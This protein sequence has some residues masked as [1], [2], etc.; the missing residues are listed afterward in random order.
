MTPLNIL[1][2]PFT[3][4]TGW[5]ALKR[6]RPS[7]AT[8]A[9]GVVLPMSL[10]PP[11]LLFYA[12]TH[13]GDTFAA[14][15]AERQWRFITTILFLAE[16]LTFFVMGWLIQAVVNG[17]DELSIDYHSAYLLAALAPLP[18]WVASLGLLVPSLVVNAVLVLAALALACSLVYHG[19]QALCERHTRD[20][21]LMSVTHTIMAAGVLAWGLLMAIVWAY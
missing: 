19:L 21:A 1:Q 14:G 10:L 6:H 20:V 2:L 8:L 17:H 12:G 11:I 3:H 16:L 9:W 7:I 13:Y 18:L 5:P 15:F 4:Q